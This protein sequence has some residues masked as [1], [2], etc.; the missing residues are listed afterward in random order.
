M[1]TPGCL[2]SKDHDRHLV[3]VAQ[4][5]GGGVHDL[6]VAVEDLAVADGLEAL[7]V[8]VGARVR[9]VDAVDVG[10]LHEDLCVDLAGAQG[11][12]GVRGEIG[13]ASAGGID[14]DA[15]LLKVANRAPPD[16]GLGDLAHL[17]GAHHAAVHAVALEAVLEREG[18]MTVASMP[19][20]SPW[21]RSIRRRRRRPRK[22][23]PP[24]RRWQPGR[25]PPRRA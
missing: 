17:D 21:A 8:G 14:G 12:G 7:G 13:V 3:V 22:M 25:P 6:E 10:G 15:P 18:L 16:V 24:P 1:K 20:L 5:R 23:L 9:V 2:M 4:G 19:M 11:G